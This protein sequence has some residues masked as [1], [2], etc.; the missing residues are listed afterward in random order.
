MVIATMGLAV[1]PED[2]V[3]KIAAGEVSLAPF[4][5]QIDHPQ[6]RSGGERAA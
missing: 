6:S 1:L 5:H 4:V 2:V 3:D